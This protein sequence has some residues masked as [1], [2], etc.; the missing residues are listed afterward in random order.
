M[1]A[2][3][4]AGALGR[5]WAASLPAGE[6]AFVPRAG[7]SG[8]SPVDF[9]FQGP[10][11]SIQDV[12]VPW[13]AL[14]DPVSLLLVTT[15]AGDTQNALTSVMATLPGNTPVVLFQNGLGSQ[16]AVAQRWPGH[17][18]LAASTTE[19]ANRPDAGT[20][21]HAG[22]GQTWIG[23]MNEAAQPYV[24][25]IVQQLATSGLSIH[26]ESDI[27]SRLWQKLVINAGINPFTAILNCANGEIL[28]SEFYQQNIDSLCSEIAA[29]MAANGQTK[30]R[31]QVLRQQI[32]T[33]AENTARNTSSMRSDTLAGRKTEIDFINGYLVRLGIDAGIPTPVNQMLTEQ[34]KLLSPNI[35]EQ[36]DG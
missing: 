20:V 2:I 22:S 14:G 23:A 3:L 17:P 4:G 30:E 24:G 11:G 32:E 35:Q 7:A 6:T 12:S 31:P 19:G 1:I 29:L 36:P 26:R 21:I 16:Q 5:L 25:P 18:V 33:V 9:Q 15:K 27:L 28:T 10:D 34:V 8:N 13:Q